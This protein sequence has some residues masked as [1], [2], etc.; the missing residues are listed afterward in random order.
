MRALLFLAALGLAV[1]VAAQTA[2]DAMGV[3]QQASAAA[4]P[5]A[6]DVIVIGG[7]EAGAMAA[8]AAAK[9]GKRV[10]LTSSTSWFSWMSGAGGLTR[11]D[12]T[13]SKSSLVLGGATY[14][15]I[16]RMVVRETPD[17]DVTRWW[18]IG[19]AGRP[20]WY[21]RAY[22]DLLNNRNITLLPNTN[23][24]S[25]AKSGT[26]LTAVTLSAPTP[27]QS[28]TYTAKIFVEGSPCGD[29]IQKGG[30]SY[31]IGREATSL[32]T[33][34]Y[35]GVQTP[36]IWDGSTNVDPYITPTVSA[37]GL[38]YGVDSNGAGTVG[39]GDG[40]PQEFGRRF[41]ITSVSADKGTFPTPDMTYYSASRYELLGRAMAS[42]P[43]YYNDTTNGL[44]RILTFY[45]VT[46]NSSGTYMGPTFYPYVDVNSG[47]P[48][49]LDYPIVSENREYITASPARRAQIEYNAYQYD[50]GFFY[51]ILHSGDSRIPASL[52]TALSAYGPSIS[53]GFGGQQ[54][55]QREGARLVGDPGH[56]FN[57]SMAVVSN[58]LV[59]QSIAKGHLDF[60]SHAVHLVVSS[61]K[62]Y[63]EGSQL[64]PLGFNYGYDIPIWV[65]FPKVAEA[66]NLVSVS[67]PSV[68]QVTWRSI[69]AIPT[70]MQLG[71]AGGI[72]A[73]VAIDQGSTVQAVSTARVLTLQNSL[74]IADGVVLSTD[75]TY[76]SG[77]ITTTGTWTVSTSRP[78]AIGSNY[79]STAGGTGATI[80]FQPN[81]SQTGAYEVF[82]AYSPADTVANGDQGRATN[83][84][85]VVSSG[86][87]TKTTVVN[88]VFP[89]GYGGRWESLGVYTFAG[90]FPSADFVSV[91]DTTANAKTTVSAIKL[92]KVGGPISFGY[93]LP[94]L[95]MA[96]NDNGAIIERLA[97]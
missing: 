60:D 47:G 58:G 28:G 81:V 19:G 22:A 12:I 16:N 74:R 94:K 71:S 67:Q 14:D 48:L 75:N 39:T 44:G 77:T 17:K 10:L 86:G 89:V 78:G 37:S 70:M 7:T 32:Y 64:L 41:F 46:P 13:P 43:T 33:E 26:T 66:T 34:T 4:T 91:D 45:D 1:P 31:S 50:I 36:V 96:A 24:V 55:Y 35:A 23:L 49:S 83:L 21:S 3:A 51:W 88:E 52:V 69:R 54:F 27:A 97:A 92:V 65:L 20:S 84:P 61:G 15:F 29:L 72:V 53:E 2:G 79:L 6:Y 87:I 85:V 68:S 56:V 9:L 38:V 95:P 63:N 73:S 76:A 59:L 62:V 8:S 80:K 30:L 42:N 90:G 40:L 11:Q 57:Q 25:V 5:R 82:F 18:R 93:D